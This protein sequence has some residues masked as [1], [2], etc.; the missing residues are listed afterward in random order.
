MWNATPPAPVSYT[1][2]DVYKRQASDYF[3]VYY[4]DAEKLII[5]GKAFVCDLSAEQVREY[6][7]LIHI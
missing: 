1:H 7:S 2:L 5:D 4:L 3:G 6:L